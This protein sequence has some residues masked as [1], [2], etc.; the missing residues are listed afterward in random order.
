MVAE[1]EKASVNAC[2]LPLVVTDRRRFPILILAGFPM[3][4]DR[5]NCSVP[6][7]RRTIAKKALPQEHNEW[8]C[9]KHWPLVPAALRR[10]KRQAEK[11]AK[12]KNTEAAWRLASMV[13]QHCKRVAIERA[14]GLL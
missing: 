9:M 10:R 5:I 3:S 11:I 6:F 1:D 7:C 4:E 12:R 14:G 13:W 8:I 2:S